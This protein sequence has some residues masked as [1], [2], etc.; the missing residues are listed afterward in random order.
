MLRN[1]IISLRSG[2]TKIKMKVK[3]TKRS[4]TWL[5]IQKVIV[6]A[7]YYVG[8]DLNGKSSSSEVWS[9][10]FWRST[11]LHLTGQHIDDV[12]SYLAD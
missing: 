2:K 10:R 9:H 3:Q 8:V 4:K 1:Q 12:F 11:S 7:L 6:V 5:Q